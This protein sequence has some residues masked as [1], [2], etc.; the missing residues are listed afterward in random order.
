MELIFRPRFKRDLNKIKDKEMLKNISVKLRQIE[1][2]ANI[3]Q[4]GGLV[5]LEKYAHYYRLKIKLSVR[6]DY[7]L[8]LMIRGTKVWAERIAPRRKIYRD[9]P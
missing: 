2:S 1:K 9:F 4:I 6:K 7:R 8:G 3:N 5:K